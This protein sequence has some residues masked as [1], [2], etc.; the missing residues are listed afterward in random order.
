MAVRAFY[1][2]LSLSAVI[3]LYFALLHI[4]E[5]LSFIGTI[6]SVITPFIVGFVIA[7]LLNPCYSFFRF[8]VVG[9]L[10]NQKKEHPKLTKGLSIFATYTLILGVIAFLLYIVIPQ[11]INSITELIVNIP[12]YYSDFTVWLDNLGFGISGSLLN[13]LIASFVK[14]LTTFIKS[15]KMSDLIVIKDITVSI[16]STV[17]TVVLGIIASIYMLYNKEKFLAQIK[18]LG[19]QVAE[20]IEGKA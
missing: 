7:Y 9:K 16:A 5:F 12:G 8:K 20:V 2:F 19:K 15:I 11:F 1:T 14:W 13:D 4:P 17:A 18:K 6:L 10:I 3:V